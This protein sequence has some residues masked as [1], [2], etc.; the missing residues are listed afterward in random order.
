MCLESNVSFQAPLTI[1]TKIIADN[2]IIIIIY[3]N[4]FA[5]CLAVIAQGCYT[6]AIYVLNIY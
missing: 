5:N 1:A 2:Q 3:I 6:G 4:P